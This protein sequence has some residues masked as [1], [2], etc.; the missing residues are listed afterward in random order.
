MG[1]A[2]AT[3]A[4]CALFSGLAFAQAP[5]APAAPAAKPNLNGIWGGNLVEGGTSAVCKTSVDA[6]QREGDRAQYQGRTGA[7]QWV[8]FEQDCGIGHRGKLG[9][10]MYKP[11]YWQEVRLHDYYAN[12]GG[13]WEAYADPEWKGIPQGVP[14]MGAP[15]KIIQTDNEVVFLYQG[16]NTFR[17]IPTDCRD[18]D[19]V[20][21]YDQTTMGLAVGCFDKDGTLVVRSTGFTDQT[22]LDWNGYIHSNEMIV[23]ETF[24][25]DGDKLT[26]GVIVEDPVYLMQPWNWGTRNL[27]LVKAEDAQLLQDVPYIDR[28]L[29]ALVDPHYRG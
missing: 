3:F 1:S 26:Y 14:R 6:W 16:R 24:K 7:Q 9:K 11:Q 19:P 29:G 15:N 22:W 21:R 8:T 10:P 12:V 23:T 25:R 17:V 18:W 13:E 28:S 20:M 27:N 4:A 2:A 5:A